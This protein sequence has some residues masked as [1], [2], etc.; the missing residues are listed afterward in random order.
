MC[1]LQGGGGG[2]AMA[3]QAPR[4]L[5][6]KG[7]ASCPRECPGRGRATLCWRAFLPPREEGSP[8]P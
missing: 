1:I 6:G 2:E 7:E 5:P 3:A 8:F 4:G